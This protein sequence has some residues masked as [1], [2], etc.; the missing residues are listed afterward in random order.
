MANRVD[1]NQTAP[2]GGSTLYVWT[3]LTV[4][5][6]C[7]SFDSLRLATV[8]ALRPMRKSH[9]F[10]FFQYTETDITVD[11]LIVLRCDDRV[12]MYV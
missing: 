8:N 6:P 12:F 9:Q 2:S 7:I 5:V 3:F 10:K 11:P 1:S 4:H